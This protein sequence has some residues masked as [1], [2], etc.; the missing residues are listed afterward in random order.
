MFNLSNKN[1]ND[2]DFLILVECIKQKMILD[3]KFLIKLGCDNIV[4]LRGLVYLNLSNNK[5]KEKGIID[6][7]KIVG[8]T[9]IEVIDFSNNI[10]DDYAAENIS[11]YLFENPTK[12]Q[13]I[14]SNNDIRANGIDTINYLH[15]TNNIAKII[16]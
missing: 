8:E 2:N 15:Y 14:F 12:I 6:L 3:E 5:L 13:L 4:D 1:L 7:L 9:K 10:I 16:I 11:K